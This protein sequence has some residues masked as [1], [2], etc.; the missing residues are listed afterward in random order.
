MKAV[1]TRSN[2]NWV[3][4]E[5]GAEY[6]TQFA[7]FKSNHRLQLFLGMR[8]MI[9]SIT[10]QST[11]CC[12]DPNVSWRSYGYHQM[13]KTIFQGRGGELFW[14][15]GDPV[16][17]LQFI[18]TYPRWMLLPWLRVSS[19]CVKCVAAARRRLV[20]CSW[21][22]KL[23]MM[24]YGHRWDFPNSTTSS[25]PRTNSGWTL[26]ILSLFIKYSGFIY[27]EELILSL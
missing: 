2:N 26:I 23:S 4:I 8:Q 10:S 17:V 13:L 5:H 11:Q 12:E 16:M 25:F 6:H 22:K 19:K 15:N 1:I 9:Y 24:L 20:W 21:L 3:H 27:L 14:C 18:A 7:L